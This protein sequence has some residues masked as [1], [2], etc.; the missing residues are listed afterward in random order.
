MTVTP[1]AFLAPV[2]LN[3]AMTAYIGVCNANAR[4][5]AV[6]RGRASLAEIALNSSAW[7]PDVHKIGNNFDNQFA[8]PTVWYS[9]CA[10]AL[11][12]GLQDT[13]LLA[14]GWLFFASRLVHHLIHTGS[15]NVPRRFHAFL[16]GFAA[17]MAMPLWL[18]LRIYFIG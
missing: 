18:G 14:L 3:L 13:V 1:Q 10:M 15:N 17:L 5:G 4:V 16:A 11:A 2:F 7:P 9:L 12:L 8:L 6:K